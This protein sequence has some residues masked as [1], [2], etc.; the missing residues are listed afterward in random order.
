MYGFELYRAISARSGSIAST[1]AAASTRACA[2]L[3]LAAAPRVPGRGG[4]LEARLLG[5]PSTDLTAS[6]NT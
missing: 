2:A 4:G 5:E 6:E 1:A 3:W